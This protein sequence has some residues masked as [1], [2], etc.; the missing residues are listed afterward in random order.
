MMRTIF[1]ILTLCLLGACAT[2]EGGETVAMN[3]FDHCQ[4]QGYDSTSDA[5]GAC[6]T[7]YINEACLAAGPVG[8]AEH[9]QCADQ[10]RDAAL[11]RSQL[12]MRGY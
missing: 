3:P 8:T 1:T 10:Q 7:N 6:M 11:V 12:Y 9:E 2:E 4:A 5:F